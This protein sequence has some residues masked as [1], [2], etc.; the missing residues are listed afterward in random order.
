MYLTLAGGIGNSRLPGP[1]NPLKPLS[2]GLTRWEPTA[3]LVVETGGSTSMASFTK[4]S[5]EKYG[6]VS[7]GDYTGGVSRT[8]NPSGNGWA[9]GAGG[10]SPGLKSSG[11]FMDSYTWTGFTYKIVPVPQAPMQVQAD[12]TATATAG[13]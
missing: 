13:P 8:E 2:S 9:A 7:I 6:S 1:K 3:S 5:D 12:A 11:G 4:H 10:S